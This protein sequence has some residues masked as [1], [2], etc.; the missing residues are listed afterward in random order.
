[1]NTSNKEILTHLKKAIAESHW[2]MDKLDTIFVDPVSVCFWIFVLAD[3]QDIDIQTK[4]PTTT[5]KGNTTL[6]GRT[7][8]FFTDIKDKLSTLTKEESRVFIGQ[9]D[10]R[11]VYGIDPEMVPLLIN[12][13]KFE[14]G[15]KI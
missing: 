15:V 6:G 5:R 14:L 12:I 10:N 3:S 13:V 7:R 1:M 11:K 9:I 2:Q 8:T 4:L